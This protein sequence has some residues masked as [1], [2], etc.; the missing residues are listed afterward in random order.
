MAAHPI[1]HDDRA[2]KA[3][4]RRLMKATGGQEGAA[5]TIFEAKGVRP[6]Q[7][8]LSDCG[9]EA[10]ADYLRLDE[11]GHLEDVAERDRSWPQVT[12]ALAS[13]HGFLLI[14]IPKGCPTSRDWLKEQAALSQDVVDVTGRIAT[15]LSDDGTVTAGETGDLIRDIDEAMAKLAMLRAMAEEAARS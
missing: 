9:N 15:A 4:T 13:R 12:R 7:Q 14:A 1:G 11:V 5:A 2:L 10:H 6:R 3:A 8:R